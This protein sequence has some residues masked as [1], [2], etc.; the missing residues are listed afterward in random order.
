MFTLLAI[1][2]AFEGHINVIQRNAAESWRR[3]HPD[4]QVVLCGDDPGV[5]E[6]A[7]ALGLEH[8]PTLARNAYGTP[9]L[10]SAFEQVMARARHTMLLYT[11]ADIIFLPGLDEAVAQAERVQGLMIGQR[12]NL[13]V[14]EPLSFEG[15]W[16]GALQSRTQAEGE[17]DSIF[18]MD[19]F[20]F[21][22]SV[23]QMILRD[24]PDFAVGRPWWDTWMVYHTRRL[25]LPVLDVTSLMPA[26]HQNHGYDHVPE[27]RDRWHGPEGDHNRALA[28][29]QNIPHCSVK[30]AT[31]V[32]QDGR[33]RPALGDEYLRYRILRWP[34]LP[35]NGH[36]WQRRVRRVGRRLL[37]PLY[38]RRRF[39]PDPLWRHVV[40]RL[41]D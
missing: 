13:D 25:G 22:K 36:V 1:P 2:K 17:L 40:Y 28:G 24:M 31:H 18:S 34:F 16:A 29:G 32:F 39:L 27:Q 7:A 37:V 4:V 33:W 8:V 15:D 5:A 21:S 10:R 9:L 14:E 23:L 12:W 11:N 38:V 41:T 6:T 20:A 26:V 30:D 3:L 19:Y 35:R